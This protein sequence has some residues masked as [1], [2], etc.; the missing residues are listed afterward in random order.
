MSN[1]ENSLETLLN[2]VKNQDVRIDYNFNTAL[3]MTI[4]LEFIFNKVSEQFPELKLEEDFPEFQKQ[5]LT[6]LQEL[7]SSVD[8]EQ[9][10][11]DL[12][13]SFMDE[14]KL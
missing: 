6:E 3:Q 14:I 9:L 10:Q 13:E 5:R 2:V 11:K 7:I 12:E 4:M 8:E 1:N